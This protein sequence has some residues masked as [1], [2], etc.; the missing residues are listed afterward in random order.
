MRA[1]DR[2]QIL[3]T[4]YDGS[5][6]GRYECLVL[7]R[8]DW[9][10]LTYYPA[11][12]YVATYRGNWHTSN[13]VVCW[14]WLERW[15]DAHLV[16]DRAGGWVE[17]YCNVITPPEL[18]DGALRFCDLDLDV[19]WHRENGLY[20]ADEDEFESHRHRMAYPDWMVERA[21]E[22]AREVYELIS[23]GAWRFGEAPTT[24]TL[25]R[26]LARWTDGTI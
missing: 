17:W 4:K 26:E 21:E 9:G 15:W 10:W 22:T 18:H 2:L 16:F 24:L 8:A 11:G 1:V 25:Q 7:D 14:R 13:S 3:S 12:T 23:R 6:H 5:P 19:V 20:I